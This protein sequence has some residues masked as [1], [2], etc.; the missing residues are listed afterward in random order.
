MMTVE[1]IYNLSIRLGIESD[2][3]GKAF[4]LRQLRKTQEHYKAL[5]KEK[6]QYYDQEYLTNP[7]SDTRILYTPSLTTPVKKILAGIDC[8]E[9]ELLLADRLG[10]IDLVISHHPEGI[11]L[12][13]LHTV[14]DLQVGMLERAGVPIH[15]AESLLQERMGE[16]GRGIHPVN[17]QKSVD[18]ARLVKMP[19]MNTHTVTDNLV[20][21]YIEKLVTKNLKNIDKISD[22]LDILMKEPEYQEATRLKS[23]PQIF[24]GSPDRRPGKIAV[25]EMTGG[26]N[27]SRDM[28]EQLSRAGIGTV[29]GM[30][31]REDYKKEAAKYHINVV[32]AGHMSSDSLGMNLFLDEVEKSGVE[33]IPVGGLIRARRFTPKTN[34]KNSTKK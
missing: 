34:K 1:S 24:C 11:A 31:I 15:I 28:F 10:D 30:H 13:D 23:G 2:P 32:I 20:T 16:V 12:A 22:I 3:R 21:L 14:M 33:I 4:V 29:I 26:T 6:K 8:N 5:S 17:D 27:G 7:Y 18:I 25:T 19:F 9:S